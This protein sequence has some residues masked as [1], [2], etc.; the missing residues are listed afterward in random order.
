MNRFISFMSA[1]NL[2]LPLFVLSCETGSMLVKTDPVMNVNVP[3]SKKT[4]ISIMRFD[5]RSIDTDK[6]KSWSMGIPDR[7][8]EGLGA[9]PYYKVISR[10]YVVKQVME[11]QTFQLLGATDPESAVKLGNILNANIIVVGSFQVFRDTLQINVKVLSVKTGQV[12]EQTSVAGPLNN[13]YTLQN[14]V[15]INIAAKM[16]ISLTAEAKDKLVQ[17]YDTKI[18]DASLANY[19][20]EQKL[21]EMQVLKKQNR[22]DELKKK[23]EE[24]K[25]DFKKAIELDGDYEKAKKNLSKV[26][27]GIPMTL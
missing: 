9:I 1:L 21:E 2:L 3:D 27:L 16:N 17:R 26:G 23:Q 15:S 4:V 18:L 5:D 6:F 7:I 14:Q 12:V 20:G 8:M 10:E 11:E 19:Q 13:F 25:K 22:T 24:A